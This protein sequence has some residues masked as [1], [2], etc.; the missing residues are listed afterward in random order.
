MTI[1]K[2]YHCPA[3]C[4][5]GISL[6]D[7]EIAISG[8]PQCPNCR[9]ELVVQTAVDATI[10]TIKDNEMFIRS[11]IGKNVCKLG[12]DGQPEI[13]VMHFDDD[14]AKGT[15]AFQRSGH[16]VYVWIDG[17]ELAIVDLFHGSPEAGREEPGGGEYPQMVFHDPE[18]GD[19]IALFRFKGDRAEFMPDDGKVYPKPL[20]EFLYNRREEKDV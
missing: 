15:I 7:E 9:R 10:S 11:N 13:V 5:W 17:R 4:G 3:G 6:S 19:E 20:W 2:R 1:K 16:G 18:S 14:G 12:A 8:N